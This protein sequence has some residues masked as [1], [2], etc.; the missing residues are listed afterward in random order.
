M[1]RLYRLSFGK[2]S[3]EAGTGTATHL[4]ASSCL[5]L[6]IVMLGPLRRRRR[7]ERSAPRR[8]S[9]SAYRNFA[10]LLSTV[11][12]IAP[13]P[14]EGCNFG[15]VDCSSLRAPSWL[16]PIILTPKSERLAPKRP[17]RLPGASFRLLCYDL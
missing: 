16:F 8:Y 7:D 14:A 4:T 2:T 10:C 9:A 13:V 5:D 3:R 12:P 6:D 17:S 11:L 1:Q 15:V